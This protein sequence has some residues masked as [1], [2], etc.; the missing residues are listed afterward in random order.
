VLRLP[1]IGILARSNG[2]WYLLETGIDPVWGRDPAL[3]RGIY[4]YGDPDFLG[5]DDPLL[6]SVARCGV[7]LDE[8]AGVAVSHLHVDHAGGLRHFLDGPPVVVQERELSYA[9]ERATEAEAYRR[10]DYDDSRIRWRVLDGD[11]AIAPGI[12]ALFT[13]GHSPGHM[14]YR[15]RMAE[16]GTWL[17]AVDAIDLAENVAL[18]RP[19]GW[20]ADPADAP[21]R[22]ASHDRLVA[23][24]A[25]ET[26]QLLPGHCPVT[27]PRL[28]ASPEFYT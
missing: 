26:A 11:A 25:A 18:D 28:L 5:Q 24:A 27:W 23:L 7:Q 14:S 10:S 19:I 13:P 17:F 8:I 21:S 1:V 22:R 15:V 12:D 2:A 3:M 16:S 20:S 9:L 6:E 4:G